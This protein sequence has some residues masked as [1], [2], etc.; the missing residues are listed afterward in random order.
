VLLL[1]GGG[2]N[3]SIKDFEKSIPSLAS[4]FRII[5]P[6]TPGQGQSAQTDTLS[7]SLLADIFSAFIDSLHLDS[8]YIMGLSDGAIVALMLADQRADKVKRIIAVGANNGTRGFNLPEGVSLDSLKI[9]TVDDWAQYHE[10]DISF[11]NELVPKKDW[12]K[13]AANLNKMWYE[14]EYF[15][16]SVYQGIKIPTLIVQGD[17]DDISLSHGLE[18]YHSIKN[19]QYCVLPNTTHEVFEEQ[20]ELI[21]K[22]SLDFFK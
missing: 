2:L 18:M 3:R 20:P 13:M 7:Y 14:K 4:S 1:S 19:S 10:K 8:A 11:Y 22:I 17:R 16:A 21:T 5:A 6:D 9:P 12:R 15:P